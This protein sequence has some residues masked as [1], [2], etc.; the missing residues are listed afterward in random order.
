MKTAVVMADKDIGERHFI[1]KDLPSA[2]VL[3]CLFHALQ[4]F[5]REISCDKFGITAG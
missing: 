4:T 2:S 1:K 5:C 3:I